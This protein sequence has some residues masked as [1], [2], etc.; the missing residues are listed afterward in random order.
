MRIQ[1]GHL[2][3]SPD[4]LEVS[5]VPTSETVNP[6]LPLNS[7]SSLDLRE[8]A[9]ALGGSAAPHHQQ[10]LT[11]SKGKEGFVMEHFPFAKPLITPVIADRGL[12][13]N[14]PQLAAWMQSSSV[15]GSGPGGS[16]TPPASPTAVAAPPAKLQSPSIPVRSSSVNRNTSP[17]FPPTPAS[18]STDSSSSNAS[19]S[20]PSVPPVKI[21]EFYSE[22]NPVPKVNHFPWESLY[23]GPVGI[24]QKQS[25]VGGSRASYPPLGR[26]VVTVVD[27]TPASPTT[28]RAHESKKWDEDAGAGVEGRQKAESGRNKHAQVAEGKEEASRREAVKRKH[29]KTVTDPVTGEETTIIDAKYLPP[30]PIV[31][32]PP[33]LAPPPS[34]NIFSSEL[35]NL[36]MKYIAGI[37][38][39]FLLLSGLLR[40]H[41]SV[42]LFFSFGAVVAWYRKVD[43]LWLDVLHHD[44]I[45][46]HRPRRN[47]DSVSS[48]VSRDRGAQRM[49]GAGPESVIWLNNTLAKLWPQINSDLFKPVTDMLEDVMQASIPSIVQQI[50][51]RDIGQ[52][53]EPVRILSMRWLD[54]DDGQLDDMSTSSNNSD[55][56]LVKGA[57]EDDGPESIGEWACMEITFAFRGLGRGIAR[58]DSLSKAAN[59]FLMV[60]MSLGLKG[61]V[62]APELPIWVELR[63]LQGTCR[64]KVQ[65]IPDPPFVK[66]ATFSLMGM[67]RIEIAAVPLSQRFLNVMSLPVI[68]DFVYSAIKTTAREFCAP[69]SYTMDLSKMLVGDD[70]K[71]ETNAIGVLVVHIDRAEGVRAADKLTGKSD[72]Y[73]TL[74]Y[75]KFA[76]TLWSSRII[77]CDLNPVWDETAILLLSEDEIKAG[78]QLVVEIWDSDRFT[79]DD[80]LGRVEVNVTDLVKRRGKKTL[81]KDPLMGFKRSQRMPGEVTWSVAFY[82]KAGLADESGGDAVKEVKATAEIDTIPFG[83]A[84]L[85]PPAPACPH[86]LVTKVPP[87]RAFP[88]GILSIQVHNIVNLS[89]HQPSS[90]RASSQQIGITTNTEE[91]E[92]GETLPSAYCSL[93]L[94]YQKIY[95]TRIKPMTSKPFF[96]AGTERFVRDWRNSSVIVVVR[97]SRMREMD[98]ILGVV[99]LRLRE[100][101]QHQSVVSRYYPLQGGIGFG[102]IRISLLFRSIDTVLPRTLTGADIG[103]IEILT[104]WIDGS[105]ITDEEVKK[106]GTITFET[107]LIKKK[108]V[109]ELSAGVGWAPVHNTHGST[110]FRLGVRHRHSSPCVLYF[111][112]D[113]GSLKLRRDKVVAAAKF[114]LKDIP[115]DETVTLKLDVFK[116]ED[117]DRFMQNAITDDVSMGKNVGYVEL[118]VGFHRG[119]GKSH[120]IAARQDKDFED[121]IKAV[122]AVGEDLRGE[123]S[124][125]AVESDSD[126]EFLE[127]SDKEGEGPHKLKEVLSQSGGKEKRTS[128]M[129]TLSNSN[130]AA[131]PSAEMMGALDKVTEEKVNDQSSSSGNSSEDEV[132]PQPTDTRRGRERTTNSRKKRTMTSSEIRKEMNRRERGV[133]QWKGARTLAWVGRG[134]KDAGRGVKGKLAMGLGEGRSKRIGQRGRN[135]GWGTEV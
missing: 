12:L 77:F 27:G 69:K 29:A 68:S 56:E 19:A 103:S 113:Q 92:E 5:E 71:K 35:R 61:V 95:K 3:T 99:Q 31:P 47:Q 28:D 76:K 30:Q 115:D 9:A 46:Y 54:H 72:C 110:G 107:P 90:T 83:T 114:W 128:E 52:G 84:G 96:N 2:A 51:I 21:Q 79:V 26:N 62:G 23:R 39:S 119:L 129:S 38:L 123:E 66:L 133:M 97:D 126:D 74:S 124:L 48:V 55:E 87:S 122:Q 112:R 130:D 106:A 34:W 6:H 125:E 53:N 49:C 43:G 131:S 132:T 127:G 7:C 20:S 57:S 73:A 10:R 85:A 70:I 81:R 17:K 78:E 4:D 108:A 82:G 16:P 121:V 50:R 32:T 86:E 117:M 101:L 14:I 135:V 89:C 8:E 37:L 120:R 116:P 75:A 104:R 109:R 44:P 59:P 15:P 36:T 102:K 91:E 13:L 93:M 40:F 111:K 100:V 60:N 98:P 33:I 42:P 41:M 18:S 67:P 134:V 45:L 88:S 118:K 105:H 63:G 25:R 1:A 64:L 24:H 22:H 94:D 80:I 11:R 65:F 58:G